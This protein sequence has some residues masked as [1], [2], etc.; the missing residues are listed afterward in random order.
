MLRDPPFPLVAAPEPI[1]IDP[2]LPELLV[3]E[4]NTSTPLTPVAP[5]FALRIVIAPLLLVIP[6]PPTTPTAPPVWIVL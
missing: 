6:A 5:A 4:L 3:P 2:L 1:E